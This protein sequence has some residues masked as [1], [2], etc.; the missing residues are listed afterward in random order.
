MS[1]FRN[2]LIIFAMILGGINM[3]YAIWESPITSEMVVKKAV[4]L[5]DVVPSEKY[6]YWDELRV[7]EKGR[8]TIVRKSKDGQIEEI[9][10]SKYSVRSRVHEYGGQSF[11]VDGEKVY[12]INDKDQQIYLL[13]EEK[14]PRKITDSK[15]RRYIDL[16]F[17]HKRELI[18]A[19]GEDHKD[20]VENFIV[21]IDPKDLSKEKV[22]LSGHDF[23]SSLTI[24]PKSE[25]IAFIYWDD[26][27]MP[28]DGTFLEL[29]KIQDDG[30]LKVEKQ[31]AGKDDVSIFQPKFSSDGTLYFVSDKTGFWNIYRHIDG[32]NELLTDMQ[33]EFGLPQWVFGMSMYDF[34]DSGNILCCFIKEGIFHLGLLDIKSKKLTELSLPYSYFQHIKATPNKGYFLAGSPK[35]PLSVIELGLKTQKIKVLK[36]S[37]DID[38]DEGYI[39]SP[40]MIKYSTTDSDHA[41]MIYYPPKNKDH[42]IKQAPPLIVISHGG[43]TAQTNNVL[44]LKIQYWT[45]RGFAVA[46]VNYRGS[47]G[48]GRKYRNKLYN[49]W[50]IYDVDDCSNAALYLA[51]NNKA[52]RKKL[53]IK[54]GSAGGYTTL[55]CLT[56]K[57]VFATGASYYGV[58]DLE[59]LAKETHKFEA[60]Y[61]DKIVAPYPKNKKIYYERSP[62]H[63]T[64][65]L[66]CPVIFFQGEDDKIVPPDQAE[67]MVEA[68]KKKKIPVSYLL[69][70]HESHGFRRAENIKKSLEAELYFYSQVL[71]MNLTEKVSP[72]SIFN[73]KKK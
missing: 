2:I 71:A 37:K 56:F 15:T 63:Y 11:F 41:Y 35:E 43:P 23:Y 27:N 31:I 39:S 13:N 28:W 33:A 1:S 67:L 42:K 70:K 66:S 50:G 59:V 25:K 6:L 9:L 36:K 34:I 58:S 29:A 3:T 47:T 53:I 64:D 68:L 65:K 18:F 5:M 19:I 57:D 54:G 38:L 49:K 17:D 21:C 45:S 20:K 26:P 7:E 73:M 10:P 24:D 16:V 62:I 69:Y 72:I 46:D 40:D 14:K 51:D 32:K 8:T 52:D 48:Y 22:A 44:N 61:L 12:F 30:S 55:A 60:H 4:G